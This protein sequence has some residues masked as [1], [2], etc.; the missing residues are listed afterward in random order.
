G[1]IM[2]VIAL[3][4]SVGSIWAQK[5]SPLTLEKAVEEALSNNPGLAEIRARAEA[6]AEIPYQAGS[7]PDPRLNLNAMNLPTD[8]FDL[9]Q[10]PMTQL[11]VGVSQVFPFPGKR[12]LRREA[13]EYEAQAALSNVRE[14]EL[15]LIRDVKSLWWTLFFLDRESEIVRGNQE[16][17][18][19][20]LTIAETKYK[21][22]R[23]LQQDVLLAQLELSKLLE[24][25]IQLRGR[26]RGQEARLNALLN[27]ATNIPIQLPDLI[28]ERLPEVPSED[29]LLQQAIKSR[30]L[31]AGQEQQIDAARAR[32]GLARREYYPDLML[33]GIY[34]LRS[35]SNPDGSE[36]SDFAS[37]M[38]S[39][40]IPLYSKNKQGRAV[41]QRG[42]EL[43]GKEFA[44]QAKR[45]EVKAQISETFSDYWSLR[46]Q[47]ELFKAGIIPQ[48]KQTVASM[49]AG[50]QVNKVDFLNLVRSQITLYNYET[51]YWK[52]LSE[53][54]QALA[55]L[56]AAAGGEEIHE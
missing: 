9:S 14:A 28:D 31:L 49:L 10:E 55:N 45:D 51:Q 54:N 29:M 38:L 26:R 42:R 56:A 19:Q 48:A 52:T 35:G 15:R 7:L 18:R 44:L 24:S 43:S 16:L 17:L 2:M 47:A 22:G 40:S 41:E 1:A 25:D 39:I 46:E 36:R 6:L 20:F 12:D 34:G 21:V 53:A 8:S 33:G 4:G 13:A 23:G 27:R 30:P 3:P 5:A 50:Y 11:Q 37:M 32:L